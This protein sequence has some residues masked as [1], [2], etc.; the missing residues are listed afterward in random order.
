MVLTWFNDYGG[1][2]KVAHNAH[3]GV[4]YVKFPHAPITGGNGGGNSVLSVTPDTP[5]ANCT[6]VDADYANSG[7]STVIAVE[8]KDCTNSFA[9][10]GFH[11][12]VVGT[13]PHF[14]ALGGAAIAGAR[15]N[16]SGRVLNWFNDYGGA[17]KVTHGAGG[18]V[19]YIKFPHAPI[20]GGNGGGNSVLSVTPDTP[21]ANCTAV[22]ADYA[23]SGASTVIAVETKNCT[24]SFAA[25]GF[26]LV[27][28]R[29]R[30]PTRSPPCARRVPLRAP[31]STPRA[32]CSPGSTPTAGRRRSPTAAVASTTSSSRTL[33]SPGGTAAATASSP[34]RRT[35]PRPT[36]APWTPTTPTA[37]LP[38]SSP[39]RPRT[40]PAASPARGFHLVVFGTSPQHITP[41]TTTTVSSTTTTV[42]TTTT[43]VPTTTTTVPSTSTS[44]AIAGARVN[45]SGTVLNWFNDYGGAPTVNHAGSGLYYVLFP[46]TPISDGNNVLSVTPDTPSANCTA[47]DADYASSGASTVV[48]GGDQGLHQQLR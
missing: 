10:R 43:T 18:G 26:H 47:V 38:R 40:A 23:N 34:S 44:A 33:P 46:N 20:T 36:A 37:A 19:Y 12:V 16:A 3:S 1:A 5:S 6:A 14:G 35:R 45:A 30:P 21:S 48:S 13:P 42:S 24:N 41:P 22:D 15:V 8:T 32:R 11:L 31:G 29:T 28:V 4:Y 17:P 7:A 27:V 9:D 39:S 25:R 2:P